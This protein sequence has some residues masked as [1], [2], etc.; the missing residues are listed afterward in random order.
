MEF[1]GAFDPAVARVRGGESY[2]A[3]T[4]TVAQF[5]IRAFVYLNTASASSGQLF[6]VQLKQ[7]GGAVPSPVRLSA[8]TQATGLSDNP[9]RAQSYVGDEALIAYKRGTAE[10][11]VLL[12]MDET[13]LSLD[14]PSFGGLSGQVI[15]G[16]NDAATGA[17]RGFLCKDALRLYRTDTTLS[18]G[19]STLVLGFSSFTLLAHSGR[20]LY[21][22]ADGQLRR[23]DLESLA[24]PSTIVLPALP[25]EIVYDNT[26]VYAR[27][28]APSG[29]VEVW[30]IADADGATPVQLVSGIGNESLR[31]TP[32]FLIA[33][34]PLGGT[35][36]YLAVPKGGGD[37]VRLL[38]G[39]SVSLLAFDNGVADRVFYSTTDAGRNLIGSVKTDDGDGRQ[40]S[41]GANQVSVAISSSVPANKLLAPTSSL[42]VSRLLLAVG[43]LSGSSFSGS[44]QWFGMANGAAEFTVGDVP[45]TPGTSIDSVAKLPDFIAGA[46]TVT[47]INSAQQRAAFR[48][49]E[50]ADSLARINP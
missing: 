23:F 8:E 29:A 41:P 24:A 26:N 12:S 31:M 39:K 25:T 3:A 27:L 22:I 35:A 50:S 1:R 45:L 18:S 28:V 5:G 42:P 34:S 32:G 14:A 6:K 37:A 49:K 44:L 17:L 21:F 48:V 43:E 4:R 15:G 47:F 38:V 20:A 2:S 46:G 9:I 16:F 30:R 7:S 33:R 10:R 36:G 19:S 40:T 13:A 11:Y